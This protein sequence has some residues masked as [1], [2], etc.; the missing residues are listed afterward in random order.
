MGRQI[1]CCTVLYSNMNSFF[2]DST[3]FGAGGG[4]IDNDEYYDTLGI[5]KD[6][7]PKEVKKLSLIHI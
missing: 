5:S 7:T 6:A 4:P 1:V 3:P 2:F